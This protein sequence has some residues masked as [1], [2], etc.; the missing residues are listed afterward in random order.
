MQIIKSQ[1]CTEVVVLDFETTG[2]SSAY[3]RVIEVGA[4]LVRDHKVIDE[5]VELMNPGVMLS[6]FITSLTGISNAMLKDKPKPEHVMP[7]LLS[8]IDERPIIAHNATFDK[9]FFLAELSRANLSSK[10]HF[11]C[12]LRLARKLIPEARSYKLADIA[13]HIGIRIN[14]TSTHRARGDVEITAKLWKH[15]HE[16]VVRCTGIASPGIDLLSTVASRGI[17]K[18]K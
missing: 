11:L 16:E 15:L 1:S 4:L 18:S 6:S 14:R 2:L 13:R 9:G 3:D 8:F 7:K 17:V 5:F 12:T 10:N